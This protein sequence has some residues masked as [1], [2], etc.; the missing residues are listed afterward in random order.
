MKNRSLAAFAALTLAVCALAAPTR[1][2]A[3]KAAKIAQAKY[4]GKLLGTPKLEKEDG[5][6]QYAV[7]VTRGKKMKEIM[8]NANTGKI[9]NVETV[10]A[11]EEAREAREDA[12]KAKRKKK[13]G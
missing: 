10:T 2:T 11:A 6:W 3:A 4:H 13:G 5:V 9:G 12:M 7:L 1:I 8:V